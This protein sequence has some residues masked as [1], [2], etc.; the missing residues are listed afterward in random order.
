MPLLWKQFKYLNKIEQYGSFSVINQTTDQAIS[1]DYYYW[2]VTTMVPTKLQVVC[3][4]SSYY[5]KLKCQVDTIFLHDACEACTN[6]FYLPARN[7]LS[8]EVGFN[9]IGNRFTYFTLE[10]KDIYDFALIKKLQIPN[11][12]TDEL[13][14]LPTELPEMEDVTIHYLNTKL[15]KKE[16]SLVNTRLVKNNT[17]NILYDYRYSV[18]CY[19]DIYQKIWQLCGLG[20][21]PKWEEKVQ[22]YQSAFSGQKHC[23]ERTEMFP[24]YCN[25]KTTI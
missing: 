13:T 4:T 10:Y 3:L 21:T 20:E 17:N 1:L 22:V 19:H 23:N 8:K 6:T 11:L 24:L 7:S 5:I 18:Y 9:K 14:K 25:V 15:R 16:L 2:A 12:T